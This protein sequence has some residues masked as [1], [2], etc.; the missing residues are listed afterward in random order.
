MSNLF[1]FSLN[2]QKVSAVNCDI[3][4]VCN[5][6]YEYNYRTVNYNWFIFLCYV[7][8]VHE[9]IKYWNVNSCNKSYLALFFVIVIIFRKIYETVLKNANKR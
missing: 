3:N 5:Y 8:F 7:T 1:I 4:W 6:I 9:K 2:S